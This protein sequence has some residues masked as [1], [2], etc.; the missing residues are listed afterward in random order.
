MAD[1][2][3]AILSV[4]VAG[5]RLPN[6]MHLHASVL[7]GVNRKGVVAVLRVASRPRLCTNTSSTSSG[8]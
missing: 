5:F 1:R 8:S 7:Q 4:M 2:I 3:C 6:C